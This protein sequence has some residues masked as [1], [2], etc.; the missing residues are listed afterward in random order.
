MKQEKP[1]YHPAYI[2]RANMA[3]LLT[4]SKMAM[5]H[6]V[7]LSIDGGHLKSLSFNE[8]QGAGRRAAFEMKFAVLGVFRAM[9]DETR[10]DV[11]RRLYDEAK[12]AGAQLGEPESVE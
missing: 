3:K 11:Y 10:A 5:T 2:K 12:S 8:W 6:D 1:D 9:P 7:M 4:T